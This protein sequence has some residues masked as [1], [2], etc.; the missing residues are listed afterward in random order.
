MEINNILNNTISIKDERLNINEYVQNILLKIDNLDVTFDYFELLEISKSLLS[1]LLCK[2]TFIPMIDVTTESTLYQSETIKT[3]NMNLL[4]IQKLIQVYCEQQYSLLSFSSKI[5]SDVIDQMSEESN[6]E[7]VIDLLMSK[8]KGSESRFEEIQIGGTN[9]SKISLFMFK[10]LFLLLLVIPNATSL[11]ADETMIQNLNLNTVNYQVESQ[12]KAVEIAIKSN[13]ETYKQITFNP[14]IYKEITSENFQQTSVPVGK[15]IAVYD[16]EVEKSYNNLFGIVKQYFFNK[17]NMGEEVIIDI[18][19]NV[20]KE[21]IGFSTNVTSNCIELMK[22]SYDS[23][24]FENLKSLDDLDSTQQKINEAESKIKEQ[25]DKTK[26]Q[27]I[28]STADAITSIAKGE[29]MSGFSKIGQAGASVWNLLSSNTELKIKEETKE[30]MIQ[31]S[32]NQ[33]SSIEKQRLESTLYS[34]SKLYC[35]Y[36]Y[37]LQLSYDNGNINVIGDKVDYSS[38]VRLINILDK[39]LN[40][41]MNVLKEQIDTNPTRDE[42]KLTELNV[43]ISLSQRLSIL[44]TITEKIADLVNFSVYSH[45][46]KLQISP[47]PNSLDNVRSYFSGQVNE[48]NELIV[49]LNQYF[50]FKTQN[51]RIQEQ[52]KKEEIEIERRRQDILEFESREMDEVKKREI[53]RYEFDMESSWNA[54]EAYIKSWINIG[55]NTIHLSGDAIG[56]LS[57]ELITSTLDIPLGVVNEI[58]DSFLSSGNQLLFKLLTNPSGWLALSIPLFTFLIYIGQLRGFIKLFTWSGK[59]LMMI[60]SGGFVFVYNL[61]STPSGYILNLMNV[62]LYN[63]QSPQEL[64][65]PPIQTDVYQEEPL[66]SPPSTVFPP[67]PP[68]EQRS[69]FDVPSSSVSEFS[70]YT[71]APV[72]EPVGVP[73]RKLFTKTYTSNELDVA[74]TLLDLPKEINEN[75]LCDLFGLMKINKPITRQGGKKYKKT[76]K[77]KKTKRNIRKNNKK[78]KRRKS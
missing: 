36:G 16:K 2:T 39:N 20:N 28:E 50:P 6:A 34:N 44:K 77:R 67:S 76:N 12:N 19:N 31:E 55:T 71:T 73:I 7:N 32:K 24:I 70:S 14:E 4:N 63:R 22:L 33:L 53:K 25:I 5:I 75:E 1:F 62:A 13:S 35:S 45:L 3:L 65:P 41:Q 15:T 10:L 26:K 18:V 43:L 9:Q 78:S 58:F 49:L 42:N 38:I 72:Y 8:I 48:L 60:I 64:P 30:V 11:N 37:N 74:S 54:T 56:D 17:E 46:M 69:T 59:K 66:P 27:A 52:I 61:I 21:L 40:F 68:L 51:I 47:T 29:I 57:K 23:K